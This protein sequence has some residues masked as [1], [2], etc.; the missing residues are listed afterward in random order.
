M[1]D[2]G[3]S[4]GST[5]SQLVATNFGLLYKMQGLSFDSPGSQY[6]IEKLK[7]ECLLTQAQLDYAKKHTRVINSKPDAINTVSP[8][9]YPPFGSVPIDVNYPRI[10]ILPFD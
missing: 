9:L 4:L 2:T 10:G 3:H 1:H 7:E 6:L 5:P 8:P